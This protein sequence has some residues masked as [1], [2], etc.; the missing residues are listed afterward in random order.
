[1]RCDIT[2]CWPLGSA[3]ASLASPGGAAGGT[4]AA[5]AELDAPSVVCTSTL[6]LAESE[7]L[8]PPAD[9]FGGGS[10]LCLRSRGKYR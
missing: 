9:D 2:T 1:M 3:A 7:W 8:L 10:R 6:P 4:G 5:A